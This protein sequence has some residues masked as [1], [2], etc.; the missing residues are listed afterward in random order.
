VSTT[1]TT[2]T[3]TPKDKGQDRPSRPDYGPRG[4]IGWIVADSLATGLV[5]AVLLVAAPFIPR[6]STAS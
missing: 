5:A 2:P 1:R 4:H 3:P 6:P